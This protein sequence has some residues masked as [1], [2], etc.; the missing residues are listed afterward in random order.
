MLKNRVDSKLVSVCQR[1]II[2]LKAGKTL[3]IAMKHNPDFFPPLVTAL[4]NAG[5]KSGEL[6]KVLTA[7]VQYYNKQK[8]LKGFIQKTLIYPS[9]LILTASVVLLFFLLY[10]L[11]LLASTYIAM[12]AQPST[13]LKFILKISTFIKEYYALMPVITASVCYIIYY[14]FPLMHKLLLKVPWIKKSYQLLM[15]ARFCKLLALLLNS[16]INITNA[17]SIAGATITAKTMLP[18]LQLLETYLQRG[19]EIST[20]FNH[21]LGLFTPLTE[22]MLNIGASTGYLPEMLEEAAKIAETELQERLEKVH[23]LLAPL[24]LLVA[25]AFTAGIVYAVMEPLFDL[26]TVIPEY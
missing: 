24:L 25:A 10:V 20:A 4:I 2:D 13:L 26:F 15:E 16:G 14:S 23:E 9:L 6:P 8:E 22:E 1:L 11:P 3:T 21:S 7:L 5:E 12:Q 17:V 18:K 19:I